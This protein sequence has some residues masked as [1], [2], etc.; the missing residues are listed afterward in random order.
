MRTRKQRGAR[1]ATMLDLREEELCRESPWSIVRV[2][3][4]FLRVRL[5]SGLR[6]IVVDVAMVC[7]ILWRSTSTN[8]SRSSRDKLRST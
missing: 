1:F 4:L 5:S 2:C 8:W 6:V 3:V 7:D